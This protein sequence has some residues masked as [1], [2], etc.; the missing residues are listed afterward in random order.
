MSFVPTLANS[1]S[2]AMQWLQNSNIWHTDWVGHPYVQYGVIFGT[3]MLAS[4][5]LSFKTFVC[6]RKAAV[7]FTFICPL[8]RGRVSVDY[9]V[10]YVAASCVFVA[11]L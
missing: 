4:H 10:L 7:D 6:S 8:Y 5:M 9:G 3:W 2:L 1:W 11:F